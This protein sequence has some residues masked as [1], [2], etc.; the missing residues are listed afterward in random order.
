MNTFPVF[1]LD[2]DEWIADVRTLLTSIPPQYKA[3]RLTDMKPI[4]QECHLARYY[5]LR[6]ATPEE[7]KRLE[8]ATT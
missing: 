1:E 4:Y 2:G 7:I 3:Y 5:W 8:D 6:D